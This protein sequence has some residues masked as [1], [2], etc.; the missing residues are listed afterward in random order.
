M[1]NFWKILGYISTA[2][3]IFIAGWQLSAWMKGE[4]RQVVEKRV[5]D[6]LYV[7]MK[8]PDTIEKT[9]FVDKIIHRVDTVYRITERERIVEVIKRDTIRYA[10]NP[11]WLVNSTDGD[12]SELPDVL[13]ADREVPEIIIPLSKT[14]KR[15]W[16]Q[17][18][19]YVAGTAG[20]TYGLTRMK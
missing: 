19:I 16:W 2:L 20:V 14:E 4:I 5:T 3:A 18:L 1:T 13:R 10:V 17:D 7:A 11:R 6:T 9:I 15:E 12:Y 8:I